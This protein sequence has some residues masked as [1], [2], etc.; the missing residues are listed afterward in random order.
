MVGSAPMMLE[1]GW[2]AN[3]C[4]YDGQ[5][6]YPQTHDLKRRKYV[7]EGSLGIQQDG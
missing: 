3:L 6:A 4:P 7:R 5:L 1:N 2:N